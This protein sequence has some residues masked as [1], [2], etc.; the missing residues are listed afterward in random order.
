MAE[1][2]D[3]DLL[4]FHLAQHF[5][6]REAGLL[7]YVLASSSTLGAG[8]ERPV[9]FTRVANE[10][11]R[12]TCRRG[13]ELGIGYSY[14][15]VSRHFDR[16]QMEFSTTAMV[17][18]CHTVTGTEVKPIRIG[19]AHPRHG[20]SPQLEAYLGCDVAFGTGRDEIAFARRAGELPLTGADP[21]LNYLLSRHGEK[22]LAGHA[23]A[24]AAIRAREENAIRPLLPH[25]QARSSEV[26]GA[27][28]MSRRTLTQRLA[29]ENLTFSGILD[30]MRQD[31]ALGYLGDERLDHLFVPALLVV[32]DHLVLEVLPVLDVD[33][34]LLGET[35]VPAAVPGH[36]PGTPGF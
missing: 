30:G 27:L 18:I 13:P 5:D 14:H 31:L 20:S 22:L 32:H 8:L 28:G 34:V 11:I 29:D 24:T 1:A 12:V 3:D 10:G 2:V 33:H 15:G 6:P 19:L 36:L 7:Y 21:Y 23:D 26:A 25:G 16:P 9:R 4:G 35:I 17:R